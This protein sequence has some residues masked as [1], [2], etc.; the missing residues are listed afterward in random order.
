M[1]PDPRPRPSHPAPR[2]RTVGD[3]ASPPCLWPVAMKPRGLTISF[4]PHPTEARRAYKRK[5]LSVPKRPQI[6]VA[7]LLLGCQRSATTLQARV[8]LKR[9]QT[10]VAALLRGCPARVTV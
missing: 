3:I 2:V 9:P 6:E 4:A 7:A 5:R 8:S 10:F 1:R